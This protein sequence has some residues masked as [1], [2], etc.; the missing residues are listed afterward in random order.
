[1]SNFITPGL[2]K[3]TNETRVKFRQELSP[4][5][6]AGPRNIDY[7]SEDFEPYRLDKSHPIYSPILAAH[8]DDDPNEELNSLHARAEE[9]PLLE[10]TEEDVTSENLSVPIKLAEPSQGKEGS[11]TEPE[12]TQEAQPTPPLE[13]S[14]STMTID[15]PTTESSTDSSHQFEIPTLSIPKNQ[16]L[17]DPSAD[18]SDKPKQESEQPTVDFQ[19]PPI[20]QP[21]ESPPEKP[22]VKPAEYPE[23]PPMERFSEQPTQSPELE[24]TVVHSTNQS[25]EQPSTNPL[26]VDDE[27]PPVTL[28]SQTEPLLPIVDE[29]PAEELPNGVPHDPSSL[30]D[31]SNLSSSTSPHSDQPE[32]DESPM[33]FQ[34]DST[35]LIYTLF[36]IACVS[37]L[38]L[39]KWLF[40]GPKTA[41][42]STDQ[43]NRNS[44]E[45][46]KDLKSL[47][48]LKNQ[49]ER[50]RLINQ[51][52]VKQ[53]EFQKKL[54]PI[55]D[56]IA[57]LR[58]NLGHDV[59]ARIADRKL[60]LKNLKNLLLLQR[61]RT[62]LEQKIH[63]FK[64]EHLATIQKFIKLDNLIDLLKDIEFQGLCNNL[65][66]SIFK[67]KIEIDVL[68]E[69]HDIFEAISEQFRVQCDQLTNEINQ[70]KDKARMHDDELAELREIHRQLDENDSVDSWKSKI[71][72]KMSQTNQFYND[73][74]Y[75]YR[76]MQ[77]LMQ[78]A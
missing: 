63:R 7:D 22:V 77:E 29:Q 65:K 39:G 68:K 67:K 56:E 70:E 66:E 25:P 60:Y 31:G 9:D 27:I 32:L 15:E 73:Y 42:T 47:Q 26:E 20:E 57:S 49:A 46:L 33:Q 16:S 11:S 59:K 50:L 75:N 71:A 37:I 43:P 48:N 44:T 30:E 52:L 38:N 21:L 17:E 54:E 61:K 40:V 36:C 2:E 34:M 74:Y 45:S 62:E 14:S 3:A 8:L 18:I 5:H 69:Q 10:E 28:A 76:Y 72:D 64:H 41:K 23:E 13:Q 55:K 6:E 35:I 78:V 58:E 53:I 4:Q 1:M 24:Q 19:Q 12:Q 51:G